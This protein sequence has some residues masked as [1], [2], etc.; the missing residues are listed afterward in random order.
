MTYDVWFCRFMIQS[1]WFLALHVLGAATCDIERLATTISYNIPRNF[2]A[3]EAYFHWGRGVSPRVVTG[4]PTPASRQIL[5]R[6]VRRH[7][8]LSNLSKFDQVFLRI[9]PHAARS[10]RGQSCESIDVCRN[11]ANF[12]DLVTNFVI[13]SNIANS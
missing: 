8:F 4:F 5:P 11:V 2:V 7:I 3:Q 13:S 12:C 10:R 1:T 6:R 9:L